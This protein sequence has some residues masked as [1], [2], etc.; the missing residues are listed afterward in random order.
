M[1]SYPFRNFWGF[2]PAW[3]S[4]GMEMSYLMPGNGTLYYLWPPTPPTKKPRKSCQLLP[5][6]QKSRNAW[7]GLSVPC[8]CLNVLCQG[9][10]RLVSSAMAHGPWALAELTWGRPFVDTRHLVVICRKLRS[11]RVTVDYGKAFLFILKRRK[12]TAA[13]HGSK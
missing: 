3:A 11:N 9:R 2:S 7:L 1:A 10:A 5:P 4:P 8:R 6:F 13:V 12:Y